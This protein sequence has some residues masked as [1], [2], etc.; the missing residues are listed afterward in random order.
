MYDGSQS[1]STFDLEKLERD[2][3]AMFIAGKPLIKVEGIRTT[4]RF[5]NKGGHK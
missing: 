1:N 5:R 4:F 2:V 3:L